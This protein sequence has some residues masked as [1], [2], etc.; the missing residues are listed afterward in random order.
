MKTNE[1]ETTRTHKNENCFRN[2]EKNTQH[3]NWY[4]Q[5]S[6]AKDRHKR[7]KKRKITKSKGK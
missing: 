2:N 3:I 4:P 6:I 7:K 5:P 1:S